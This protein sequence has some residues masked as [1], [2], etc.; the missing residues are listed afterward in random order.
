[1]GISKEN[2]LLTSKPENCSSIE[3]ENNDEQSNFFYNLLESIPNPICYK[4]TNSIFRYCNSAFCNL[5]KK[6]KKD[7]INHSIDELD[8]ANER[9]INTLSSGDLALLQ[10]KSSKSIEAKMKNSNGEYSHAIFN[11]AVVLND[12]NEAEGI[13]MIIN[14]ITEQVKSKEKVKRLNQLKDIALDINNF[15]MEKNSLEEL[16]DSILKKILN[17]NDHADLGCL[18]LRDKD[19]TFTISAS[20]GYSEKDVK[21]FS[22]KLKES[23]QWITTKGNIKNTI[24]INDLQEIFKKHNIPSLNS[25]EGRKVHSS[26]STPIIIDGELYGLLNIDSCQNYV[27]DENDLSMMEYLRS[28][29]VIAIS[30]FQLYESIIYLSEHDPKTNLYNRGHFD[31]LFEIVRERAVRYDENFLVVLF[32]LN[33]LKKVN[34]TLGHLAGDEI[35]LHFSNT[36]KNWIRTS[37]ILA[38]YG[39]D[40]FISILFHAEK[41]DVLDRLEKL[42]IQFEE[43][44][45]EY[46]GEKIICSFSYGIAEFPHHGTTYDKLVEV[47]DTQMYLYKRYLKKGRK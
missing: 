10:T 46:E 1:M 33:G 16:Y 34:D 26:I 30:K 41:N 36:L 28:Q 11:K 14:D 32:D 24:I 4:D 22:F 8:G 21:R 44:P 15:I 9:L 35:I 43:N 42:R 40:E 7:I 23:F 20:V 13:I 18:I 3:K 37:D 6:E 29:L 31:K 2:S 27:F 47:A 38:R 12:D 19:D 25:A 39:G 17:Y 5:I 45:I